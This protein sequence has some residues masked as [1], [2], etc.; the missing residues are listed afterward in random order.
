VRK[1]VV[2]GKKAETMQLHRGSAIDTVT[3]AMKTNWRL[4]V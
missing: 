2:V 1:A 4:R 3:A